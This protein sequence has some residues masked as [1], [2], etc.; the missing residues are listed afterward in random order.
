MGQSAQKSGD[1]V[2]LEFV[3]SQV[4]A[5]QGQLFILFKSVCKLIDVP[6]E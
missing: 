4:Q 6:I 5:G 2:G 3:V 1:A